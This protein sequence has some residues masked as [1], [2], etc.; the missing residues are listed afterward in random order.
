[1]ATY[2]ENFR[3]DRTQEVAGSTPASSTVEKAV[4]ESVTGEFRLCS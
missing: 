4:A 2:G 3:R 1:M